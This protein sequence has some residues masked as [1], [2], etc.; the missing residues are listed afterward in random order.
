[1]MNRGVIGVAGLALLVTTGP[2]LAAMEDIVVSATRRDQD[3]QDVPLAVSAFSGE[4]IEKLQMV[5]AQDIGDAVPNLLTYTVTAGA[6]AMQVAA[7]GTA[8]QNPG[9]N[10]SE[11]PVGI[12]EDDIYRGRLASSNLD[13]TD[14][15]RIEVLRGPQATLYGRNTI[16]GAIKIVTRT[17]GDDAWANG[18]IGYGNFDTAKVTASA[19]GPIEEGSL[20]GSVAASWHQRNEG[21]QPNPVTGRAAGEFENK[22]ARGKLHWYGG[23]VID[24]TFS[25]WAV[26]QENDGYNGVPYT[27]FSAGFAAANPGSGSPVPGKPID[28]FYSNLSPEGANSG[29]TTQSGASLDATF[30]L[31]DNI[32]LR[33]IT[34]YTVIDDEFAFDLAGGGNFVDIGGGTFIGPLPGLLV[35]SVSDL[36]QVSQEFHL[37]GRSFDDRLDWIIGAFYLKEEGAQDYSGTIPNIFGFRELSNS[38][39]QSFAIFA[40][41]T[42]NFTDR[43]SATLGGRWTRDDKEYAINCSGA[44]TPNPV[45]GLSVALDES[46]DEFTPKFAIQYQ[47]GE[48]WLSFATVSRGFQAGGFQTLCFGNLECAGEVYDPQTVWN[49]EVGFK[50]EL[51]DNTVRLNGAVFYAQYEDIQQTR[52]IPGAN[53]I[54]FVQD[55]VGDVDVWGIELEPVWSPADGLNIFATLGYQNADK[56]SFFNAAANGIVSFNLPSTPEWTLRAGADYTTP[57]TSDMNLLLGFDVNASDSYFNSITN[58]VPVP[59]YNRL[60]GFVGLGGADG[61]WSLILQ[62]RNLTDSDDF[63]SGLYFDTSANVRTVLPPREYMLN[64]RVDF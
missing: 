11:S 31:S 9:F 40:E 26:K 25:F 24:A 21:W 32:D 55:N 45:T 27:P 33:S 14:V 18:S 63:V 49:Y 12:Y 16:A 6:Q 23:D 10:V 41:G 58:D 4:Q 8:I 52:G 62:A 44:C 60:N 46:F 43:F 13:L 47:I 17:P 38:E 56:A 3:L 34:A 2:V 28:G 5:A 19:G 48:N 39:T 42:F 61:N 15:E 57:V 50:G 1:M 54:F 37:L 30:R 51:F 7:R 36:E 22:A 64:L 20:A 35:N 53:G 29:A 59:S